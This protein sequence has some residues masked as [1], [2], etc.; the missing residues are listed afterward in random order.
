MLVNNIKIM[1]LKKSKIIQYIK[2]KLTVIFFIVDIKFISF[3]LSL[4]V[5]QNR[6]NCMIKLLQ[7]AYINKTLFKF[8]FG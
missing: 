1:A 3:Y 4:K 2:A 8:H 5:E 6:A 7:L